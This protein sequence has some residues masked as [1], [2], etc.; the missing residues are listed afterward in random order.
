M[1]PRTHHSNQHTGGQADGQA[2]GQA[3]AAYGLHTPVS[4]VIRCIRRQAQIQAPQPSG[5]GHLAR[6]GV[7]VD[8]EN[9]TSQDFSQNLK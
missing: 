4:R 1:Y 3:Y 7:G 6:G 2:D 5:P 8:W 9:G